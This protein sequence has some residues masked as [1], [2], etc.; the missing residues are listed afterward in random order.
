MA[1]NGSLRF[2]LAERPV[3]L[4]AL[5][6]FTNALTIYHG[7]LRKPTKHDN[8]I[9]VD[10]LP[11]D[12]LKAMNPKMEIMEIDDVKERDISKKIHENSLY[13]KRIMEEL[14]IEIRER[15]TFELLT[16]EIEKIV[17]RE[18]EEE[19]FFKEEEKLRKS[20]AKLQRIIDER[21]IVNEQEKI[22]M[23]NELSKEQ[24]NVEKLKLI[25]NMELDYV[26]EWEKA[27][28]EQNSLRCNMEVKKL[29]KML[30]D[31]RVREKNERRVHAELTKFLTQETA[32]LEK[33]NKEW[34][35]RYIQEKKIYEKEIQ[36]LRI[37]IKIIQKEMD[38]L[39]EEYR[40]NQKFINT[41][42]AEKEALKKEKERWKRMQKSAIKIQAWWR[43]VMVRRKLGPYRLAEKKKKRSTK[44]K[45]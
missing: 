2:S 36:Q 40:C 31:Q 11:F 1:T 3:I 42:L 14:K 21:K 32:L 33:K 18:K 39:K 20:T 45:K 38:K 28:Y 24:D 17:T 30:K 12:D 37:E 4:A 6:E 43:G 29:E 23:L 7:T 10:C 16:E 41:Y 19:C 34:K 25:S 26:T 15:G 22:R 9:L 35:E 13:V 27:R 5:E 44:T 8:D